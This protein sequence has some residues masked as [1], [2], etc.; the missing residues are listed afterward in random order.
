M[1]GREYVKLQAILKPT[2]PAGNWCL[3]ACEISGFRHYVEE[4]R[5]FIGY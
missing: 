1:H 3:C 2:P 5:D 4:I